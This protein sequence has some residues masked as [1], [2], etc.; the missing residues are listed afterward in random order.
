MEIGA[1]PA[2]V[3]MCVGTESMKITNVFPATNELR[4]RCVQIL[5][6]AFKTVDNI[7]ITNLVTMLTFFC[8]IH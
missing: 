6:P 4:F 8:Y 5:R 1:V 2:R 3:G 7:L